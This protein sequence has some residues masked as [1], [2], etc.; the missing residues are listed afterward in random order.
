MIND[1]NWPAKRIEAILGKSFCHIMCLCHCSS[2]IWLISPI[3]QD[4]N[5]ASYAGQDEHVS[6]RKRLVGRRHFL[7][8]KMAADVSL[9]AKKAF[10][11][12]ALVSPLAW[13]HY[14]ADM[15]GSSRLAAW[16][17]SWQTAQLL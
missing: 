17:I 8:S 14:E 11:N 5:S 3:T 9:P 15:I 13:P 4:V 10:P 6:C 7:P 16:Q 2:S 1:K 12:V